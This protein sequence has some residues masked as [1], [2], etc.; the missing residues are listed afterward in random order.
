M[1]RKEGM[2]TARFLGSVIG[3]ADELYRYS[4]D[5]DTSYIGILADSLRDAVDA[6]RKEARL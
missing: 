4:R 6:F 2:A 3:T 1:T 5:Y